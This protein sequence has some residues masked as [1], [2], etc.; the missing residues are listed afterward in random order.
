[1][2]VREG[3]PS[4]RSDKLMFS[5]IRSAIGLGHK[6]N[7]RVVHF[8]VQSNHLHL[9]V[10]AHDETALSRGMQSLGHRMAHAIHRAMGV[11]EGSS[12]TATTPMRFPPRVRCGL[13]SSTCSRTGRS[14][15]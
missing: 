3:L 9:I 5:A 15:G 6:S 10:E 8:S 2:R 1:M 7:F 4:L 13:L 11:G 14:M 12:L